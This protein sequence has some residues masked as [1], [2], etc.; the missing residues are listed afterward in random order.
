MW[1]RFYQWFFETKEFIFLK[2]LSLWLMFN[3]CSTRR[4]HCLESVCK[5]SLL[6]SLR[7]CSTSLF[8]HYKWIRLFVCAMRVW[9]G[10]VATSNVNLF[11]FTCNML[12]STVQTYIH[13]CYWKGIVLH[14]WI[15]CCWCFPIYFIWLMIFIVIIIL[16]F[17]CFIYFTPFRMFSYIIIWV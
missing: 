10:G 13:F 8:R 11:T 17:C 14:K 12:V 16:F 3:L 7:T 1:A 4:W 9:V 5:S 6:L 15:I 2:W